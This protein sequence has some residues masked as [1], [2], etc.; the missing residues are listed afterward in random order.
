MTVPAMTVPDM[1]AP[2]VIALICF[3]TFVGFAAYGA[4]CDLTS[5]TI[6]NVVSLAIAGSFAVAALAFGL[7]PM[8]I[9]AH[10]GVAFAVFACGVVLFA[11]GAFGGGDVKMLAAV[12]LWFGPSGTLPMILLVAVFGGVVTMLQL[13]GR[14]LPVGV[15]S[16]SPMIERLV[17]GSHGVPYGIAI[18]AGAVTLIAAAPHLTGDVLQTIVLPVMTGPG[19]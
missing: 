13:G 12:A 18:A 6:P 16:A 10:L 3:A 14:L 1:S 2:M 11:V 19:R 8:A 17:S 7:S 4:L 15:R 9:G 5:F